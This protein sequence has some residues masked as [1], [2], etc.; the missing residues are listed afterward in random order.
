MVWILV[1]MKPTTRTRSSFRSYVLS[2]AHMICTRI[3]VG[4]PLNSST[5]PSQAQALRKDEQIILLRSTYLPD[6]GFMVR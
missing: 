4:S 2:R 3:S 6:D 1:R 5:D